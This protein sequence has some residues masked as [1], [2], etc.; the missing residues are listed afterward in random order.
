MAERFGFDESVRLACQMRVTGDVVVRRLVLDSDDLE[1]ALAQNRADSP[2]NAVGS[3]RRL[4]V[5]FADLRGFT[6]FAERLPPYDVIHVLNRYFGAMGRVI[7]RHGGAINN[8]MGDG[9]LALFPAEPAAG[10]SGTLDA[11]AAALSMLQVMEELKPYFETTYG[12]VLE[13]GIGLHVGDVV[14]GRL[15]NTVD[16]RMTTIGDTVNF[17]SR[18]EHANKAL[19]T[20]LLASDE[21]AQS[22]GARVEIARSVRTTVPG[23]SGEVTLHEIAA[24]R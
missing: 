3:E 17:A 16:D 6:R 13:I 8:T 12:Q 24:L 22:L 9:L 15:A 14:I 5:M 21:V 10:R 4:T 19:G 11:T 7:A 23:R 1:I 18:I 2:S 20:R